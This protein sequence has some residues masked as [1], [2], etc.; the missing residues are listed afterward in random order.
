M[1]YYYGFCEGISGVLVSLTTCKRLNNSLPTISLETLSSLKR[2]ESSSAGYTG[3]RV[4]IEA[5][6]FPRDTGEDMFQVLHRIG[7][8]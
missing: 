3:G 7:K 8:S 2:R 1:G 4:N 6:S 5:V